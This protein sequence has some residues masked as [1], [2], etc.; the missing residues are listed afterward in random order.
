VKV[1]K[2]LML[3]GGGTI[4]LGIS[5]PVLQAW[6]VPAAMG[7][8]VGV[9]WMLV[10]AASLSVG[11]ASVLLGLWKHPGEITRALQWGALGLVALMA[12]CEVW[13][14]TDLLWKRYIAP[15]AEI[16]VPPGY[17]GVLG[18]RIKNPV[19]P[20]R[21]TAGQSYRYVVPPTGALEV[22]SGW[23][24]DPVLAFRFPDGRS[25]AGPFLVHIRWADGRSLQPDEFAFTIVSDFWTEVTAT[26][27][28]V[29]RSHTLGVACKIGRNN[30]S[31]TAEE[32][33]QFF[34]EKFGPHQFAKPTAPEKAGP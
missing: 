28:W 3:L 5:L 29:G 32:A 27:T 23:L 33:R 10:L 31:L 4:L 14:L 7:L 19:T 15:R 21:L 12:G 16:I 24:G 1:R 8:E 22:D 13:L 9:L 6:L 11:I 34:S 17:Q 2:L 25:A 20:G 26:N 18:I 30:P